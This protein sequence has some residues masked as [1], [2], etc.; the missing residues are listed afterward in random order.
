VPGCVAEVFATRDATAR[1]T[2]LHDRVV[3]AGLPWQRV[4]DDALASLA[5]TVHPQGVVAV[6]RFV[7]RPLVDVLDRVEHRMPAV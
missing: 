5:E 4:E 7:D 6:C 1:E 2:A 3:G